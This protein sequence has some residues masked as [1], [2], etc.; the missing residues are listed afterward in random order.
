MIFTNILRNDKTVAASRVRKPKS[1]FNIG[2]WILL[3]PAT[4]LLLAISIYPFLYLLYSSFF[5]ENLMMSG[6]KTFVGLS[7]FIS[8]FSDPDVISGFI[9]TLVFVVLSVVIEMV[10]GLIIALILDT[11]LPGMKIITILFLI[12]MSITPIVG[13]LTWKYLLTPPFGWVDFY[14]QKFDMMSSPVIWLG[15][16]FTAMASL[17]LLDVWKWTPFV[18]LILL[19][20][21]KAQPRDALEAASIDGA[22]NA[23]AFRFITLPFLK[24]FLLIAL[25]LRIIGAFKSF[26]GVYG[27][28]GGGPGSS[29]LLMSLVVYRKALESFQI[30][31]AAAIGFVFLLVLIVVTTPLVNILQREITK[32]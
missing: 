29:T 2:M 24:R 1:A 6:I 31:Y 17:I 16:S 23:Q 7:N 8:M 4:I 18:A 15:N 32:N 21:L 22:S 14:L 20:G 5:S 3:G 27:L 30:G 25:V 12:P 9:N 19:A 13:A 28:T 26:T 11:D 10:L